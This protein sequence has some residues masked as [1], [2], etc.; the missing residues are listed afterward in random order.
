[1]YYPS[2]DDETQFASL[3]YIHS[4]IVEASIRV[5]KRSGFEG[6]ILPKS[7]LLHESLFQTKKIYSIGSTHFALGTAH[8]DVDRHMNA[9]YGKQILMSALEKLGVNV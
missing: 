2:L 9:D 4:S 3:S 5:C 8:P 6:I 7:E 1:M